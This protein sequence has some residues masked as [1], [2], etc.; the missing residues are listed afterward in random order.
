M[1]IQTVFKAGNSQVVSIP[2][3]LAQKANIKPG[4]RVELE[5]TANGIAIKKI[6]NKA[7]KT[8]SDKDFKKWLDIFMDENGE[9]LDELA[10]R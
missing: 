4:D 2:K 1:A 6:E 7:T 5:G 9:I 8:K 10:I 3:E